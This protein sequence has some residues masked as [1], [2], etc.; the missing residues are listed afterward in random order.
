MRNEEKRK[1][2]KLNRLTGKQIGVEV[3]KSHFLMG[4]DSK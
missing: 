3:R 1:P 2:I 4:T